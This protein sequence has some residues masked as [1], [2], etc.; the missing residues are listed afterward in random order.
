[1]SVE[2]VEEPSSGRRFSLFAYGTARGQNEQ[3]QLYIV[4]PCS[5]P[6]MLLYYATAVCMY[7]C[8]YATLRGNL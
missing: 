6:S 7:V 2:E 5:H 1:M 8:T 4:L 3:Y